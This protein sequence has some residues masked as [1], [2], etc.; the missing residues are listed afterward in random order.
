MSACDLANLMLTTCQLWC[1]TK[2]TALC[3]VVKKTAGL[4]V[5]RELGHKPLHKAVLVC[6]CGGQPS[7]VAR[8][9][10]AC[11]LDNQKKRSCY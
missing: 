8:M 2:H 7:V 5:R 10:S 11:I 6:R 3:H 1:T 9:E 4:S